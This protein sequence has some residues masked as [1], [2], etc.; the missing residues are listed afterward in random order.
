MNVEKYLKII[1]KDNSEFSLFKNKIFP[2]TMAWEG[3][4]RLHNV[5]GDTGGWTIWGISWNNW[6]HIF[7]N[8]SD[9]KDTLRDEAAII[10]FVEFYLKGKVSKVPYDCKLFYFDIL[11]NM[12]PDRGIKIMQKCLGVTQ[13]GII[14]P[15]TEALMMKLKE[16]DLKVHRDAFYINLAKSSS[17][18]KFLKGWLNRSNGVYIHQY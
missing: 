7:T 16:R 10:S 11:Y 15:K 13:D 8:F 1:A 3:G 5:P 18:K 17:Y 12:G 6:K 9:F 2:V 14:G 4:G